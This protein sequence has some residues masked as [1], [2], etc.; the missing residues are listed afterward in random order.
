M[1][2]RLPYS[3]LR[4]VF[5]ADLQERNA[6]QQVRISTTWQSFHMAHIFLSC[7]MALTIPCEPAYVLEEEFHDRLFTS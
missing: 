2:F 7:R 4:Q 3:T 1:C 6:E 5:V